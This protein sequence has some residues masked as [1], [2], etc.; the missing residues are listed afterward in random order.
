MFIDYDG[1]PLEVPRHLHKDGGLGQ[2]GQSVLVQTE[3]ELRLAVA[4]GWFIDAN[5]PR[6]AKPVSIVLTDASDVILDEVLRASLELTAVPAPE[7][8]QA[9]D[10]ATEDGALDEPALSD[11]P[12]K[13]GPGRPRKV[14]HDGA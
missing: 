10:A 9:E 12:V 8:S 2:G 1:A 4:A 5:D 3:D 13:R 6:Q 7:Q 11:P 14:P